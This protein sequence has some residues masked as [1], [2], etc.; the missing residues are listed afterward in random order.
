MICRSGWIQVCSSGSRQCCLVDQ[1]VSEIE[2]AGFLGL[3]L[4]VFEVLEA[5]RR[6]FVV[7]GVLCLM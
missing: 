6:S 7:G 1:G 2:G 4:E 3:L 5:L